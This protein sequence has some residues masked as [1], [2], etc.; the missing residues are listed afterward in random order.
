MS[1]LPD[2]FRALSDLCL[3]IA[4]ELSQQENEIDW[5]MD[6]TCK[7]EQVLKAI[8]DLINRELK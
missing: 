6:K 5:V 1:N 8:G 7:N 3:E 2:K 4:N